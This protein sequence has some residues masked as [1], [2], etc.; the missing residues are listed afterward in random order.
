MAYH[1]G[2]ATPLFARTSFLTKLRPLPVGTTLLSP[3]K[4]NRATH[5]SK[6]PRTATEHMR[7]VARPHKGHTWP[8]SPSPAFCGI[9]AWVPMFR[10]PL[11]PSP[12]RMSPEKPPA[13]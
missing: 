7:K 11:S 8:N 3:G 12:L 4:I 9:L 10:D 13:F 6:G 2:R 5:A 1:S